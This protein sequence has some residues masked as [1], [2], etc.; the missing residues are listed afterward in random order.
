MN[1]EE[2]FNQA[3]AEKEGD[4]VGILKG[5]LKESEDFHPEPY[6]DRKGVWTIGYGTA[7]TSGRD[8]RSMGEITKEQAMAMLEEDVMNTLLPRLEKKEWFNELDPHRQAALVSAAYNMGMGGLDKFPSMQSA[9]SRATETDDP[10]MQEQAY[11]EAAYQLLAGSGGSPSKYFK[12][13]GGR[14]HRL[15]DILYYGKPQRESLDDY[16]VQY[17][18]D[19]KV[20]VNKVAIPEYLRKG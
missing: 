6:Q 3:V 17:A 9:L 5:M 15:A 10:E 14:A 12:D 18:T 20:D 13:V 19:G 4:V 16:R 1:D 8:I 11:K 7:E 2:I